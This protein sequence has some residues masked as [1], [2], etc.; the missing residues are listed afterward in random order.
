MVTALDPRAAASTR[1][2]PLPY[3]PSVEQPETGEA[4]LESVLRWMIRDVQ[5]TTFRHYGHAM[6]GLQTK[7]HGLLEGEL[8]VLGGLP[9]ELAQGLF[10]NARRYPVVMRLSTNRGDVIDDDI[11]VPRGFALKV[12]GVEGERLEGSEGGASQDFVLVNQPAFTEPNLKVFARNLSVVDATTDTG[13][14]WKKGLGALL[15]PVVAG[16][17]ALGGRAWTL[18]TMGGHPLTHPLGD[19][20]YSQVPFRFGDHVAKFALVP[21]SPTLASLKDRPVELRGRPNGL[22]EAVIAFFSSHPAE[23]ELRVQLRTNPRTMPIEDASAVWPEDESPY[24]T[25]ARLIAPPQ[26]AW[27]EMRAR[28]VD[29]RLAFSPWN[30]LAAHRPL[31]S[32]NR[33]RKRTYAE[34]AAFRAAH[35]HCPIAELRGRL[36]LSAQP[37]QTYGTAPGRE[38]RRPRT[39]DGRAG[40]LEPPMR[41]AARYITAGVAISVFGGL[42]LL[43]ARLARRRGR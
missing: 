3:D 31:G 36:A 42:V 40:A 7:S 12:V 27:S 24:R 29:D 2:A 28:Q 22:R 43:S 16:V 1:P 25:V 20:Y 11:S 19:A 33:A 6:R 30:G 38:G 26:P 17:K 15:R 21:V 34:S 13:L 10:A 39:P 35:N 18:T 9:P 37:A 41:P 32:V 4:E 23:W 14:A 8:Q 5:T